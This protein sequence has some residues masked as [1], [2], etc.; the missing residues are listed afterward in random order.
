[1]NF[2]TFAMGKVNPDTLCLLIEGFFVPGTS[3]PLKASV[4]LLIDVFRGLLGGL[5]DSYL[6]LSFSFSLAAVSGLS[7]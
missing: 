5:P 1:M 3:V 6:S 7:G 4:L 2:E